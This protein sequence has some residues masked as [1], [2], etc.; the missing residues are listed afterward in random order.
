MTSSNMYHP[1][2]NNTVASSSS[3]CSASNGPLEWADAS[4]SSQDCNVKSFTTRRSSS[5]TKKVKKSVRFSEMSSLI[6]YEDNNTSPEDAYYN[7]T[8]YTQFKR[9]AYK[10]A[11]SIRAAVEEI[12]AESSSS[13]QE[14]SPLRRYT[15]AHTRLPTLLSS[16][17][18]N[19]V[20]AVGIEH[21]I[22]GKQMIGV[23]LALR[24]NYI[25]MI[26]AEQYLQETPEGLAEC[27]M[28]FTKISSFIACSRA[29]HVANQQEQR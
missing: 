20:H 4:S 23:N 9:S 11:L 21:L 24:K 27:S 22:I 5:S 14:Q 7:S 26:L 28:P 29:W 12:D 3:S 13:Q 2:S 16:Q 6:C 25:K 1:Y 18:I 19:H 8:D 17:S 15:A 10:S